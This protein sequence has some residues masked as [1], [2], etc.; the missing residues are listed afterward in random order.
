MKANIQGLLSNV[1]NYVG[2]IGDFIDIS[3]RL[4]VPSEYPVKRLFNGYGLSS[5]GNLP[6]LMY[7][8][9]V[10]AVMPSFASICFMR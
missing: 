6:I 9:I 8:R 5:S 4:I 3:I 7:L 2:D 1:L 10:L